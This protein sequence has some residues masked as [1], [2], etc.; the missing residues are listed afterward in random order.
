V[1]H[2]TKNEQ[3]KREDEPLEEADAHGC[4]VTP[5]D[6][7]TAVG[8]RDGDA[9]EAEASLRDELDE[10][11]KPVTTL[12]VESP[13]DGMPIPADEMHDLAVAHPFT[14]ATVVCVEDD[15]A[16]VELFA[17]ELEE[18]GFVHVHGNVFK[19][20][21][22][23]SAGRTTFLS[24]F[25]AF[26]FRLLSWWRVGAARVIARSAFDG[27]GERN[28]RRQFSPDDVTEKFGVHVVE[29][30]GVTVPVR[31]KRER[32]VHFKRQIMA[33]DDKPNPAE[34]GH[35]IRFYNCTA[36]KSVGGAYMTLRDEAMYA[37]DYR[38]PVDTASTEQYL[39]AWDRERLNSKRHLELVRPFNLK[40]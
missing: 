28:A 11:F 16:F 20:K 39:D 7:E 30:E 38:S 22:A 12:M 29:A 27:D 21:A 8:S 34:F 32:C 26:W 10:A 40:D 3:D 15:T 18:R 33:N 37:C 19:P 25:A 1:K 2:D 4:D 13:L 14:R 9:F 24:A 5:D 31:M 17:E 35:F 23:H 6:C 36:R